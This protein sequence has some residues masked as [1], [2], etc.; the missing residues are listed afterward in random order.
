MR[1]TRPKPRA[2]ALAALSISAAIRFKCSLG[3]VCLLAQ[4]A[5]AATF[6]VDVNSFMPM[7]PYSDWLTAANNIQDAIDA[8]SPGDLILVNDGIYS[9]GG[10]TVNNSAQT[11]RVAVNKAVTI[12]SVNGPNVT[13][14][15]GGGVW[16]LNAGVRCVYLASGATLNGF[17]L[18]LGRNSSI[19][20]E[21]YTTSGG[22]YCE[23]ITST[24]SNCVITD[25]EDDSGYLTDGSAAA[26][27]MVARSN[28]C[29]LTNNISVYVGGGAADCTLNNCVLTGNW[30]A[31]AGGGAGAGAAHCTLNNCTLMGNN[32]GRNFA[33]GAYDCTLNNCTLT[34][35]YGGDAAGGAANS[36]LNNCTLMGNAATFYGGGAADS[37]LN[38]CTLTGNQ[39]AVGGAV[40]FYSTLKNCT[41]TDNTATVLAVVVKAAGL[42]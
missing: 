14:I 25:N 4:T 35:N 17:T 39:A 34:D 30:V 38:N 36:T 16:D 18:T 8:A 42:F 23:S 15:E 6:Y 24:V 21:E 19:G 12:Q 28:N 20:Y 2:C 7:P 29:T 31:S 32:A 22:V 9:S 5:S 40:A 13:V 27:P 41:L 33:G 11:N 1:S 10:A 3:L 37:T 26:E